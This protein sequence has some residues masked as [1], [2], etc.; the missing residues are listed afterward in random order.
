MVKGIIGLFCKSVKTKQGGIIL[1]WSFG[2]QDG[3]RKMTAHR[4]NGEMVKWEGRKLTRLC[5]GSFGAVN[6]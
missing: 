1:R 3:R 4:R 2:G 6:N 5:S